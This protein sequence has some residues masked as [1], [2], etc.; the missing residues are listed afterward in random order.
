MKL[1]YAAGTVYRHFK[2]KEDML[3]ALGINMFR[4]E[5]ELFGR[6]ASFSGI[7]REKFTALA[8]ASVLHNQLFPDHVVIDLVIRN[9]AVFEK[10]TAERQEKLKR[11]EGECMAAVVGL[12]EAAIEAGDLKLDPGVT[13]EE[14][15]FGPWAMSHGGYAIMQS[16]IPLVEKG[17]RNPLRAIWLNMQ[18]M[19]DGYGWRP[20][21]SEHD[22]GA[23]ARRAREEL[24]AE[25]IEKVGGL[26]D[27]EFD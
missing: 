1:E 4:Q 26:P 14:C 11:W 2:S 16:G 12:Y 23:V 8:I 24:F 19:L 21:A 9:P 10:A 18:K 7:T 20:L 6:A 13:P 25:E 3:V 27:F 5:A 22:Y 15:M 17:I